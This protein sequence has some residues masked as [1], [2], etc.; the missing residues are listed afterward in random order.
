MRN[1]MIR[2]A[3]FIL[4]IEVSINDLLGISLTGSDSLHAGIKQSWRLPATD[5]ALVAGR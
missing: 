2:V 1:G 5:V 3:K 4:W